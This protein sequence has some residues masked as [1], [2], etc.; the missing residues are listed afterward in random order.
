MKIFSLT[1]ACFTAFLFAI[2]SKA[3]IVDKDQA[4]AVAQRFL[5]TKVKLVD[6][7]CKSNGLVEETP[8]ALYI[9]KKDDT[10]RGGF[11]I[12]SADNAI[13]PIL[14]WSDNAPV[15]EM[16]DNMA[17]WIEDM[18]NQI[19]ALRLDSTKQTKEIA[20]LWD[21]ADKYQE[22]LIL[23]TAEWDQ[24]SPYNNQCPTYGGQRCLTGC[25][26]TAL[27]IAMKYYE[28][29]QQSRGVTE[30][31]KNNNGSTTYSRD[32]NHKINWDKMPLTYNSWTSSEQCEEVAQLMADI[33]AAIKIN[34]GIDGSAGEINGNSL[35]Y[36]YDY[37]YNSFSRADY[38]ND[39]WHEMLHK[40]LSDKHIILYRGESGYYGDGHM[41]LLDGY[42][43][44]GEDPYYH[45]NW[46]WGGM[47][48]GFFTLDNLSPSGNNHDYN[49]VQRATFFYPS[50]FLGDEPVAKVGEAL[51]YNFRQAFAVAVNQN[52]T[53]TLLK[54]IKIVNY[55]EDEDNGIYYN[56]SNLTL[57]LN[58]QQ[59]TTNGTI[60][61]GGKLT[62]TDSEGCGG[63]IKY[64]SDDL[65]YPL[66]SNYKNCELYIDGINIT[67]NAPSTYT[68][69]NYG[70]ATIIDTYITSKLPGYMIYNQNVMA[71]NGGF[72]LSENNSNSWKFIAYLT[73]DSKTTISGSHFYDNGDENS[74][75]TFI[76]G[77]GCNCEINNAVIESPNTCAFSGT[78]GKL[79]IKDTYL[80]AKYLWSSDVEN[81]AIWSG[82]FSSPVEEKFLASP[83]ITCQP[84]TDETLKEKYPY[85]VGDENYLI[86]STEDISSEQ[87]DEKQKI[88]TL[89]GLPAHGDKKGL[90]I[91][92]DGKNKTKKIFR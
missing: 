55:P 56:Y 64:P 27:A 78:C 85:I 58:G 76:F 50:Y 67:N 42:S 61:N 11:A 28:F 30:K 92:I 7:K 25:V 19:Y 62:I 51:F 77:N 47:Y 70:S 14:A 18:E 21:G 84:N 80:L 8:P 54:N 90:H 16:P 39:Q 33:G 1:L 3:D 36:Y 68:I 82:A 5:G 10:E 9:F 12:V 89:D 29:P 2:F 71:I 72:F 81:I 65:Y 69:A 40:E 37:Y 4:A 38:T 23:E 79:T 32:L 88:Y 59:L 35:I 44:D 57:D 48:N 34:Y 22:E 43:T 63:I 24:R 17:A 20:A 46:G 83:T 49:L 91:I 86:T 26:A 52:E 31:Y 74:S 73:E 41:F 15:D 60:S 53:L 87:E 13:K 6:Q 75:T 66:I 45:V